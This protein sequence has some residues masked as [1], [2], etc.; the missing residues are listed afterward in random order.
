MN[1]EL[2]AFL[3]IAEVGSVTGA[4]KHLNIAQ[5]AV[6]KTLQRLESEVGASLFE[7][8]SKGLTLTKAG[9]R[10]LLHCKKIEAEYRDALEA[11][12]AISNN[13]LELFRVGAGTLFHLYYL[14]NVLAEIAREFPKTRIKVE[15]G[16]ATK[17]GSMLAAHELEM[18]LGR[19]DETLSDETIERVPL[20]DVETGIILSQ[21]HELTGQKRITDPKLLSEYKWVVYQDDPTQAENFRNYFRRNGITPPEVSIA[22]A[23]F[24]TGMQL[25]ASGEYLMTG[26]LPLA[27]YYRN[28]G[29]SVLP[30]SDPIAVTRSG[31]WFRKSSLQYPVV[32]RFA[33]LMQ[34]QV[35]SA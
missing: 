20:A 1:R 10:F 25:V 29:L 3:T 17:V 26:P 19:I 33:D 16:P 24:A 4:A 13:H 32:A 28:F 14:P 2:R 5:P 12:D 23:S 34:E 18:A 15:V 21:K 30:T 31:M 27:P 35:G 7:R 11:V 22:T 8:S 6:S 9:E